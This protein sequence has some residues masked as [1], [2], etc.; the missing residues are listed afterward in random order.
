VYRALYVQVGNYI[1]SIGSEVIVWCVLSC[2]DLSLR[3]CVAAR[4]TGRPGNWDV[5]LWQDIYQ[6][7]WGTVVPDL[8][9]VKD[10]I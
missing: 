8:A 3:E 5:C 4:H 6:L 7:S 9:G 2:S 10:S 1:L